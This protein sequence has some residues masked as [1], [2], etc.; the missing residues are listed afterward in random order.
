VESTTFSAAHRFLV[1]TSAGDRAE[2]ARWLRGRRNFDLWITYYGD[3]PGRFADLTPLYEQRKGGKFPNLWHLYRQHPELLA[4]YDAVFVADDDVIIDGARISRLFEVLEARDL[5][6]LQPAFSALGRLSH[7]ITDRRAWTELRFTNFVEMTCPLFRQDKLA[8]F[9]GQFD[10]ELT[11][12]GADDWFMH[13]LG[14]ELEG[15]VAVVDAIVCKNPHHE[16]TKAG[17]REIDSLQPESERRRHWEAMAARLGIQPYREKLEYGSVRRP[18]PLGQALEVGVTRSIRWIV[19]TRT[20]EFFRP[21]VR[22]I[23]RAVSRRQ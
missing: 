6:V 3:E 13:S 23:R 22:A 12:W 5:W 2:V 14:P 8:E 9:M 10:P 15:R 20:Y 19:L 16:V 1:F 18:M 11:G 21:L 4:Q 17:L 7:E